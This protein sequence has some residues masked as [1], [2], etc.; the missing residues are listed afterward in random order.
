MSCSSVRATTYTGA[1]DCRQQVRHSCVLELVEQHRTHSVTGRDHALDRHRTLGD[2]QLVALD[3]TAGD[4]S[5]S[6]R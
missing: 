2:E 4:A 1:V 3:L 5:L 6:W